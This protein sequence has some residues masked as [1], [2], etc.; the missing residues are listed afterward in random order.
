MTPQETLAAVRA[1]VI[2]ANPKLFKDRGCDKNDQNPD[3]HFCRYCG[4]DI[5]L[6]KTI[7][8]VDVLL[9]IGRRSDLIH[10]S[11]DGWF[12]TLDTQ[13]G[14]F[15]RRCQWHLRYDDLSLQPEETVAFI[16]RLLG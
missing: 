16:H 15:V 7:R 6:N 8:L 4:Y 3:M 9:M 14:N 10:V 12:C 2:R 5:D 1:A 11:G 13:S